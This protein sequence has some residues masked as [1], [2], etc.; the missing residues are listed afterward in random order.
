MSQD[1]KAECGWSAT[2]KETGVEK[3]REQCVR[4]GEQD[5]QAAE[6]WRG[7]ALHWTAGSIFFSLYPWNLE[8]STH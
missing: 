4:I 2:N 1:L 3:W 6:T 7:G 8:W 5:I